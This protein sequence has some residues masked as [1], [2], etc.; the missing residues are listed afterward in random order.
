MDLKYDP[1]IIGGKGRNSNFKSGYYQNIKNDNLQLEKTINMLSRQ[2][3]F[4]KGVFFYI[5]DHSLK[6]KW[7]VRETGLK[8]L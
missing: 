3:V 8:F 4:D 7:S 5:S 2:N 6:G 1:T